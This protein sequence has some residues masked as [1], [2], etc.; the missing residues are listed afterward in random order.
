MCYRGYRPPPPLGRYVEQIWIFESAGVPAG[1]ERAL[2]SGTAELIVDL[3]GGGLVV[4]ERG[5]LASAA[6]WRGPVLYGP[7]SKFFVIDRRGPTHVLG[8][9]FRPGGAAPFFPLPPADLHNA[10]APLDALWGHEAELLRE[11]VLAARDDRTRFAAVERALLDRLGGARSAHRAVPWAIRELHSRRATTIGA[12]ADR[13]GLS[14][15]RFAQLFAAE[16]GL[17]PKLYQRVLRFQDA[18]AQIERAERVIW[19]DVA[20]GCGYYDQAHF[21]H[22]FRAFAGVSPGAYL[23]ARGQWMNHLPIPDDR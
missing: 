11:R 10:A 5:S 12:L 15:R 21:S 17:P 23:A 19:A 2:P 4:F 16:I 13:A 14:Q 8:V 6:R 7:H 9:H 22:D 20:L 18:L 1:L 3:S